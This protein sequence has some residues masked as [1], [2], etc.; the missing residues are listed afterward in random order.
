MP[1]AKVY[2]SDKDFENRDIKPSTLGLSFGN[3]GLVVIN[4]SFVKS[5]LQE[6]YDLSKTLIESTTKMNLLIHTIHHELQHYKQSH[7][8]ENNIIN[9]GSY[10]MLKNRIFREY[11]S[12]AKF[13]EYKTNYRYRE[14]E[15]E[16][17]IVGWRETAEFLKKYASKDKFREIKISSYN[18]VK[19]KFDKSYAVSTNKT[20][21]TAIQNN[22]ICTI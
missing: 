5:N 3:T 2:I 17:N 1:T 12:D 14:T 6:R 15:R 11:L 4:E 7:N 16:A 22:I 9:I 13:N 8:L 21:Y 20:G 18:S 10:N 19:T